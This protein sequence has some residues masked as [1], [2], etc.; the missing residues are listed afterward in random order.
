LTDLQNN[1]SCKALAF[2]DDLAIVADDEHIASKATQVVLNWTLRNNLK[3][4]FDKCGYMFIRKTNHGKN[5]PNEP[6]WGI[7][8]VIS[9]R[10]LGTYFD[11]TLSFK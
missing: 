1:S 4:N 5:K 11:N 8:E 9:Y 6:L 3:I 7:R 2:A 10:Y